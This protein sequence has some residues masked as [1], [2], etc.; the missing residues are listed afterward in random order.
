MWLSTT[1]PICVLTVGAWIAG[2][3]LTVVLLVRKPRMRHPRVRL[4]FRGATSLF[5]GWFFCSTFSLAVE[6]PWL[7]FGGAAVYY[8]LG[9][10]LNLWAGSRGH[11]VLLTKTADG[12]Y[13]FRRLPWKSVVASA[14]SLAAGL[15][16]AL[17]CKD[18]LA[19]GTL[20]VGGLGGICVGH[21]LS[22]VEH[23]SRS[24][25]DEFSFSSSPSATEI[26]EDTEIR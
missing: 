12:S 14:I 26:T 9:L 1:I 7:A 20:F 22:R 4:L 15:A 8:A 24:T 2:F 3:I 18:A 6:R 10:G 16:L 25:R 11:G 23:E 21:A 13:I 5:A 19:F 17:A